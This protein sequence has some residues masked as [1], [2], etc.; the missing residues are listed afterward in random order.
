MKT[1][2]V[3]Q[4]AGITASH[5]TSSVEVDH[6]AVTSDLS[7]AVSLMSQNN[8]VEEVMNII[9]C[10]RIKAFGNL[11]EEY[12]A[13]SWVTFDDEVAT[14]PQQSALGRMIRCETI[15]P[16]LWALTHLDPSVRVVSVDGID[17]SDLIS[18][19]TMMKGWRCIVYGEQI[20]LFVRPF[21]GQTSTC[22]W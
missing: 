11:T 21:H 13:S 9:R 3:L 4:E 2:K 14:S 20:L 16:I 5:Q 7:H 1:L 18:R 10:G 17:A 19:N 8:V 22:L 6:S 12:G 15:A